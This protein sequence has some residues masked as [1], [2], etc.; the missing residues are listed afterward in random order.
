MKERVF[1]DRIVPWVSLVC[2]RTMKPRVAKDAEGFRK[3]ES[4]IGRAWKSDTIEAPTVIAPE[5][6]KR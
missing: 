2:D 6:Q 4:G 3:L 1:R 5:G